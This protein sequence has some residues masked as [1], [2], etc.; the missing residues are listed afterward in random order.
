MTNPAVDQLDQLSREELLSLVRH[1]LVV[2]EQQQARIVELEAEIAKLRQPPANSSNSSQPPAR[3]QK[4]NS[5][6]H[7]K[8]KKHGPPF[9]HPRAVSILVFSTL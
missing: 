1:L 6:S 8:H 3:D 2:V 5:P 9:G 4:T 7:Q